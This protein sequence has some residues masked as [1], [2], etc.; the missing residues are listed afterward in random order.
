MPCEV[1][2]SQMWD[3][4]METFGESIILPSMVGMW[5]YTHWFLY[6]Y[7]YI[8]N[9]DSPRYCQFWPNNC[10]VHFCF[11]ICNSLMA[12]LVKNPPEMQ[13]TWVRF[14]DWEDPL[15]KGKATHQYFGLQNTMDY[16]WGHEELD[17]T[18]WLSLSLF[19]NS[20]K[21]SSPCPW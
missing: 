9:H 6:L 17:M 18:E 1:T 14:L 2:Q 19:T 20:E 13:E 10:R 5:V 3:I 16:L 8:R 21:P 7:E 12:Q 15:E 11:N 4:K